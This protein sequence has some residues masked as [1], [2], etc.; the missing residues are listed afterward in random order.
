MKPAVAIPA[1]MEALPCD[2]RGYPVPVVVTRASDGRPLFAV[3]DSVESMRCVRRKLCP[4]CGSRL[5]KDLWFAGGPYAAFHWAGK[6]F[7]SAM[8]HECMEY[9]LQVCPYLAMPRFLIRD[10]QARLNAVQAQTGGGVWLVDNT[11]T[12]E[13]PIVF[14]VIKAYGQ[15]VTPG[16]NLTLLV[17]PMR[18]YHAVEFWSEGQRIAL[19]DGLALVRSLYGKGERDLTERDVTGA[20]RL[21]L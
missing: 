3:N 12:P 10:S 18:P 13:R 20:L 11:Q 14:V 9:A 8:H 21:L 17:A 4:I 19:E 16:P 1:R 2:P 6:Y 15:T 5:T 7:D